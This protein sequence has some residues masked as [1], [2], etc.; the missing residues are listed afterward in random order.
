MVICDGTMR[1]QITWKNKFKNLLR[2]Q[3]LIGGNQHVSTH[4]KNFSQ[5]GNLPQIGVKIKHIW[6]HHLD[7]LKLN[8]KVSVRTTSFPG[9]AG[10]TCTNLTQ[11]HATST[12]QK[13]HTCSYKQDESVNVNSSHVVNSWINNNNNNNNRSPT[14]FCLLVGGEAKKTTF[15]LDL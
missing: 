8:P 15:N 13:N 3:H 9:A 5:I 2:F 7:I 10:R 11:H 6:N 4:L 14:F 12:H 1:K